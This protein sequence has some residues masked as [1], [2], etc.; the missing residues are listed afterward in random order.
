MKFKDGDRVKHPTLGDGWFREYFEWHGTRAWVYFDDHQE[1]FNWIG[2]LASSLT[3]VNHEPAPGSIVRHKSS[4]VAY[5]RL[6]GRGVDGE[7]NWASTD[8]YR[9]DR[10]RW[11]DI[12]DNVVVVVDV[13]PGA[14]SY[15]NP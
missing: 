2:V 9:S 11:D 5:V 6:W 8:G 14:M 7:F 13:P 10:L 12:K 15:D 3:K 1:D 4:S